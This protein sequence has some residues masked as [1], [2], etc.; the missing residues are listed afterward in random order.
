MIAKDL[1]KLL[2]RLNPACTRFLEGAVGACVA[3]THYE[4]TPV[5]LLAQIVED[6]QGDMASILEICQ[7]ERNMLRGLLQEELRGHKTG[8]TARPVFSPALIEL[9]ERAWA[10]SSLNLG[11][12]A[13]RSAAIVM[14]MSETLHQ[15]GPDLQDFFRSSLR[16][17]KIRDNFEKVIVQ[18]SAESKTMP[19]P[20]AG[21][22]GKEE[23]GALDKFTVDFTEMARKGKIDPIF[24]RDDEIRQAIDILSRRRKNNPIFIGEAGVGKTAVVEGLALKIAQGEVPDV[25]KGVRLLSLD[26]GLLSAGAGVRGEFEN[27]LKSVIREVK[28][29]STP[30][31]LFIDEAHTLIGAGGEAGKSDAANLLKPEL[32]RGEM[33][34]I[35]ATTF[36]EF[37]KY[38]EKDPAIARRFQQVVIPEPDP[39]V[40]A[41]MLRGLREK[42]ESFHKVR[43]SHE[44]VEAACDLSNRF[45][46]GRQLPDKAVDLLDTAAAR[47][48]MGLTTRP[49]ELV[50]MDMEILD[51]KSELDSLDHDENLKP[52]VVDV[53]RKTL[54]HE[55]LQAVQ[56]KVVEVEAKWKVELA[57]VHEILNAPTDIALDARQKL[58]DELG[59]MQGDKPLV[60]VYVTSAVLSQV[61]E[62]WTGIPAG[63]MMRDEAK[64][65]LEMDSII[66]SRVI[67][68]PW[69]VRELTQ[70]IRSARMG[71]TRPETPKGVFLITG[72]SGVGKTEVAKAIADLLY[73]GERSVVT[74]S[75]SEYQDSI[76]VTALKGASAGYVGYGDGG[77]LTEGVRKNPY[78]V[79]ILD[80]IEKAHKDVLN[81]FYQVF[82]QGV[83]RD[84]EGRDIS[85][86]NTVIIMTSNL[87]TDTIVRMAT[88]AENQFAYEEYTEAITPEL[89]EHFMPALLARCK[90]IP[91]LPLGAD[92]LRRIVG[93]KL[94][95]VAHRLADQ[96][97]VQMACSEQL[98]DHIVEQCNLVQSG[99]R[100]L[101]SLLDRDILPG[102]SALLLERVAEGTPG[103]RIAIGLGD[104]GKPFFRLDDANAPTPPEEESV[105]AETSPVATP[106]P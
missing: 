89:T 43:I 37:R 63:N 29:S 73:G 77:V 106:N 4:A 41:T 48:R 18:K 28:E 17:E 21:A 105:P 51:I 65:L 58:W 42:Y 72:P 34:C 25:I 1:R 102:V 40:A 87:G 99:A 97:G 30:V 78:T 84:G 2:S 54:L 69:G 12:D 94:D 36:T 70:T 98:L 32:A 22:G 10:E 100:L 75:M 68:Q 13:I 67:G 76:S 104:D 3:R 95:K 64:L 62:E 49:A 83:I 38:L 44:A 26:L 66:N 101:D 85:F 7:L 39:T 46:A 56:A 8:N 74:L 79:V 16:S 14:A 35:A 96:H 92:S 53:V 11:Q 57:K 20:K 82:D 27:R 45:I 24:G 59:A 103:N 86:R 31:I 15:L 60:H 81:L 93:Q 91:F 55:R 5:H 90:V 50:R 52:G 61:I 9:L 71:L 80:E 6:E 33:K 19:A 88:D 47:V 23:G